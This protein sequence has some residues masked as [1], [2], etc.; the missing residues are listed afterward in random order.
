MVKRL[1]A[2]LICLLLVSASVA[3]EDSDKPKRPEPVKTLIQGDTM[4]TVLEPGAIPAI[5]DPTF[6]PFSAADS[7]YHD[8]EP[9]LAMVGTQESRGY[10][11]WHLDRHEIVNDVLD[12]RPIAITW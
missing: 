8:E 2:V 5:F 10:S 11:T 12:G 9:L 1:V 7:L 3:A 6:I 4:Y